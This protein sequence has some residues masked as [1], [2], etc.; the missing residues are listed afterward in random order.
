VEDHAE[1]LPEELSRVFQEIINNLDQYR[2]FLPA[3]L[4]P[5]TNL[6]RSNSMSLASESFAT[7]TVNVS[8]SHPNPLIAEMA[9]FED[10]DDAADRASSVSTESDQVLVPR[11]TPAVVA[12]LHVE[13]NPNDPPEAQAVFV[14]GVI[15]NVTKLARDYGGYLRNSIGLDCMITWAAVGGRAPHRQ[16]AQFCCALR[17]A[18]TKHSVTQSTSPLEAA[19]AQCQVSCAIAVGMLVAGV[20]GDEDSTHIFA[21]GPFDKNGLGVEL[22][23]LFEAAKYPNGIFITQELAEM[24]T[25]SHH[26]RAVDVVGPELGPGTTAPLVASTKTATATDALSFRVC[27]VVSALDAQSTKEATEWM[28]ALQQGSTGVCE[29]MNRAVEKYSLGHYEEAS[30]VLE[31]L[32]NAQRQDPRLLVLEGLVA[33]FLKSNGSTVK[34]CHRFGWY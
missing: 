25:G 23:I 28:Y 32:T 17:A 20:A 4:Q 7:L 1:V 31:V 34:Y 26:T 24:L 14:A 5:N 6:A 18:F 21:M 33:Q 12:M 29:V 9:T 10:N 8:M 27:E 15:T 13:V 11:A 3:A 19:A 22:G 30:R 16:I 2:P